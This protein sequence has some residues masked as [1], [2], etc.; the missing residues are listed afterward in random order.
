MLV[1]QKPVYAKSKRGNEET[2]STLSFSKMELWPLKTMLGSG[3]FKT[4]KTFL[5]QSNSKLES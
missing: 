4:F 3:L 1:K 2:A 5:D